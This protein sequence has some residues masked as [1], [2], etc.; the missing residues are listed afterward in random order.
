MND[1]FYKGFSVVPISENNMK[2]IWTPK[3]VWLLLREMKISKIQVVT[4]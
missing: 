2:D 1:Q 4:C 3:D